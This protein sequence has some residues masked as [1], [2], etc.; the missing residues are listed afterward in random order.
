MTTIHLR[1]N[2]HTCIHTYFF[3]SLTILYPMVDTELI[4]V[5]HGVPFMFDRFEYM[6]FDQSFFS[7]RD[8][9]ELM[10]VEHGVR[11]LSILRTCRLTSLFFV[12]R[13]TQNW[14]LLSTASPSAR[15]LRAC[16]GNVRVCVYTYMHT[17][18]CDA[19]LRMCPWM[20]SYIC[21]Y[22]HTQIH[23]YIHTLIHTTGVTCRHL[24]SWP[25]CLPSKSYGSLGCSQIDMQRHVTQTQTQTQEQWDSDSGQIQTQSEPHIQ[26]QDRLRVSQ[27][28]TQ[29]QDSGQTQSESQT[30]TQEQWEMR[31]P[32]LLQTVISMASKCHVCFLGGLFLKLSEASR[33]C[34]DYIHVCACTYIMYI[35]V[36]VHLEGAAACLCNIWDL[37]LCIFT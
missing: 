28:Q 18:I 23:T 6:T 8:D 30:Q 26:T 35:D 24:Q 31:K 36:R 27:T 25:R 4:T 29:T 5:E 22:M 32:S 11:H 1:Y 20:L 15:P 33:A 3:M 10:T 12:L 37:F 16:R 2:I 7:S 13:M 14:L 21:I 17:Y 34:T 19:C 9:T